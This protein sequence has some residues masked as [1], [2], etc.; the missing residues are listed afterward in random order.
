MTEANDPL[1][2]HFKPLWLDFAKVG[3]GVLVAGGYGLFLK[4]QWL[5][6]SGTQPIVI[7]LENWPDTAP[8]ATND[9]DLVV[10]LDLI[11]DETANKQLLA[12]LKRQKFE[13]S[14]TP[15]GKRWQFFKDIG[16]EQHVH[17]ELHAPMPD[18]EIDG[19][20]ANRFAVKHKPVNAGLIPVRAA[21]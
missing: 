5:L 1:W 16:D 8:R 19:L 4:Q 21:G 18:R 2:N 3:N 20:T 17:V 11:S 14:R 6:D 13:V 12:A 7:P 10:A 15:H 9:M